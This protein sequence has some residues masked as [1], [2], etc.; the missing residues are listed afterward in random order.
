MTMQV[1]NTH[2]FNAQAIADELLTGSGA[3][4]I[5]QLFSNAQIRQARTAILTHSNQQSDKTATHFQGAAEKNNTLH[6]QRRVW[7][8]LV[9]GQVFIDMA[10]QPLVMAVM[11]KFLG[12]EF[13]MGS[14]AANR[15]LPG[16]PGQEPH[17]DYPYW[18]IY[19][20]SSFPMS[21]AANF[22]LNAQVTIMLDDFTEKNG[23]SA[24]VPK[25]YKTL[26]YPQKEDNF[27]D[28]CERMLGEAGDAVIFFGALWHCAMPNHSN[29][30]RSAVLVQYLPKF[31]VPME[32]LTYA[33]PADFIHNASPMLK[34]LLSQNIPYPQR[35]DILK[36]GNTIGT[37]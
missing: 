19:N 33:L 5:K 18:D 29:D 10:Q 21:I 26:R 9:K 37:N 4:L 15:L 12:D 30:D 16:G 22:P 27:F 32:D 11:R 35:L 14:I 2:H 17:I 34:Q 1:F 8:L 28:K 20:Q 3:V 7:N 6:L 25:S 24:Y 31:I 23:A 36:Q 13:I